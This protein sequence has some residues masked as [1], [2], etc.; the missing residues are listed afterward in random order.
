MIVV[1][2]PYGGI[3]PEL[4]GAL[5]VGR[6]YDRLRLSLYEAAAFGANMSVPY[7]SWMGATIQDSFWA[8]HELLVEIQ[9][10]VAAT[11]SLRSISSAHEVAVVYGVV[12]QRDLVNRADSGDNLSN[13]RDETVEVPFRLATEALSRASCRSTSC[14]RPTANWPETGSKR[15][16]W[17]RTG[18]LCCRAAGG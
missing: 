13:A 8:P 3:V 4:V 17:G 6:G 18:P 10:F 15:P 2:N 5:A 1:E 12:S 9:D 7:G 16:A 11:G 14:S